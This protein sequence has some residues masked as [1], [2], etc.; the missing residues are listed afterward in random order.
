M[1]NKSEKGNYNP[2]L[3]HISK[4]PKSFPY[5]YETKK[6]LKNLNF[7]GGLL[8]DCNLLGGH[9]LDCFSPQTHIKVINFSF[10]SENFFLL[11]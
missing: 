4:N 2:N 8:S 5:V 3:V 1:Q 6:K 10:N 11:T 7:L 9:F